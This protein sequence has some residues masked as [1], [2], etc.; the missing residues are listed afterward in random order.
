MLL[1]RLIPVSDYSSRLGVADE[2]ISFNK[3][4][5]KYFLM[6]PHTILNTAYAH[7]YF[8]DYF[9]NKSAIS[10]GA[11]PLKELSLIHN[12][13]LDEIRVFDI[14][15]EF[16]EKMNKLWL[17][18]DINIQYLNSDA[19]TKWDIPPN[20][21]K[22]LILFQMDYI[23]SD[24]EIKKILEQAF[25]YGIDRCFVISPSIFH[26]RLPKSLQLNEF[27]IPAHDFLHSIFYFI[28]SLRLKF[29]N[30]KDKSMMMTYK[31]SYRRFISVFKKNKYQVESSNVI[32]NP[33]GSFHF[34]VF[35]KG[36]C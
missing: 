31:R 17:K 21:Y 33:N 20:E 2:A 7:R 27:A 1:K 3:L 10:I 35:K 18:N 24:N 14:D 16:N 5:E 8:K 11:D 4:L 36:D 6:E 30:K 13:L 19:L 22:N 12:K 26:F 15:A 23:F 32:L 29:L 28:N 25:N 34:F 9:K